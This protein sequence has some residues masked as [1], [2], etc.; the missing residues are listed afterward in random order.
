MSKRSGQNTARSTGAERSAE[1]D[2]TATLTRQLAA[3][4]S[5]STDALA[6]QYEAITGRPT[7]SRNK[8]SLVKRVA[9]ALQAQAYGGLSDGARLKISQLGDTLPEAW[10]A[11]IVDPASAVAV[12]VATA[13]GSTGATGSAPASVHSDPRLPPVGATLQRDYKGKLHTVT[14][15]ASGFDFDGRTYESLSEVARAITGA[16]WNGFR[17]F[18]LEK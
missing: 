7:N 2:T 9:F 13:T 5:K 8:G 12:A 6:A 15:V 4:P 3:L 18:K 11:R 14:I 1:R 17:F 16:R 10:Q